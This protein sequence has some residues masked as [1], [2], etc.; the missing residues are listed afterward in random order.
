L[1]GVRCR[2]LNGLHFFD[3]AILCQ[4]SSKTDQFSTPVGAVG[5]GTGLGVDLDEKR[6]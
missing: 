4:R 3:R 5:S 6:R 1:V 2:L